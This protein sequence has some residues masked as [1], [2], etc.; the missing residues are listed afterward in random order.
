MGFFNFKNIF[1]THNS[2][3]IAKNRLQLVLLHD[4]SDISP[5]MLE[6]L[7]RDIIAVIKNYVE[8]DEN[9]IEL[10]LEREDSS[11]ALVAN[12][13]VMTVRRQRR[14]DER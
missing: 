13:P 5:E 6:N 12:I 4:R 9:R 14:R 1:G 11:V 3:K 8:I 10:D 2:G 7:K